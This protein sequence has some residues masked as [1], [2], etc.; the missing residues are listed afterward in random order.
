[1]KIITTLLLV[2]ITNMPLSSKEIKLEGSTTVLPIA[3][4]A[5]EEYMKIKPNIK[6][7]VKGG[8]SG[9]G[10]TSIIEGLC[11]I[12]NAS[13]AAKQKELDL[14]AKK[15]RE[16]K[17]NIIAM[18]GIA[19]V[20]NPSNPIKNI[21]IEQLRGIYTGKIK[22]W[23]ELGGPDKKIIA[24][25]RE[26]SSGTFEFFTEFVLE[27]KRTRADAIMQ[28]SNQGVINFVQRTEGAIGYVG[29]GYLSDKVKPITL[30]GIEP[31]KENVLK[32]KYKLS[33]PLYM[34]TLK[35]PP[36]HVEEFISFIKGTEGSK[37]IESV[38][39]IPLK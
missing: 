33:R 8:G 20:V 35:N 18:D 14:A 25:S 3:Q 22:N 27:K 6:I 7:V 32:N 17:V 16:L 38:G 30:E 5:A 2:A 34:Y 4:K 12:A 23:K 11:D 21:T 10:I 13:R 1:M 28:A 29:M 24:V 36:I 31:T 39:F 19:V 37:I 9:V 15:G 26:N